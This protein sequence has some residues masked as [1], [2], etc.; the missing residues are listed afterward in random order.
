MIRALRPAAAF[1][2]GLLTVSDGNAAQLTGLTVDAIL[3]G[4]PPIS[5]S[6]TPVASNPPQQQAPA[7]FK[8]NYDILADMNNSR[9]VS[10]S[11]TPAPGASPQTRSTGTPPQAVDPFAS[12]MSASPRPGAGRSQAP[13]AQAPSAPASSSLLDLAG[14]SGTAPQAAS[15]PAAEDDEWNF[16]SSLPSSN[17]LPMMNKVQV[18]NSQLRIDFAARRA[19]SAP[20]QI[21]I[22]A[23]FSNMSRQPISELHFQVAV[24]KV[25]ALIQGRCGGWGEL[26]TDFF[27][28]YT[29]QLRPQSGRDIAPQQQAGVQQGM[30]LD[31]I[32][33]G[34]GNSVKIRFKASYKLGSE[35]REEQGMV[36]AL[37]I[38]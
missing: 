24:E 28:S 34:K 3:V 29:L 2:S 5:G 31:G 23:V 14:G 6:S 4:F 16:A 27:Q 19:Q 10:Q 30:V 15:K 25:S 18:L 17:A 13:A 8:P 11:S 26:V 12:L 22:Q 9:P 38:A 36:P 20:R 21:H 7:G 33:S 1:R 37:G 35:A 32:E